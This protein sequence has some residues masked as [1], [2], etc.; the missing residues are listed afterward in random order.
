MVEFAVAGTSS[1]GGVNTRGCGLVG[2]ASAAN[3]QRR[4]ILKNSILVVLECNPPWCSAPARAS[5][6][7]RCRRLTMPGGIVKAPP[8]TRVAHTPASVQKT[9]CPVR[10]GPR[11][12]EWCCGDRRSIDNLVARVGDTA[13][14]DG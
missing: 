2:A 9:A 1:V 14:R 12:K 8:P 11:S 3:F 5:L 7:V 4:C 10:A 13:G 6:R